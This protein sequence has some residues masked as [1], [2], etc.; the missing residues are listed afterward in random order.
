MRTK[1][2]ELVRKSASSHLELGALLILALLVVRSATA[3]QA[4]LVR[5]F[6]TDASSGEAL[7]GVNVVLRG[8][9][10]LL[11][12]ATD[13]D[14]FYAI[15]RIPPGTYRLEATFV[16]YAPA[17]D[18]LRLEPEAVVVQNLA[19]EPAQ[20]ALDE[21]V[22]EGE[23][24]G[25]AALGDGV[26]TIQ[27]QDIARIPTPGVSG[28]LATYLTS[29]PSVVAPGDQGG[30]L[31]IRGGEPTQNLVLLDG[32][33]VYQP[34]H[35][36]GFYSAFPTDILREVNV[37]P[38]GF[39]PRYG[40][41]LS[42][43]IDVAT[44]NGNN[45]RYGGFASASP[46]VLAAQVEGPLRF[47]RAWLDRRLSFLASARQ[48][49]VEEAAEPLTG[50]TIPYRFGDMFAKLHGVLARNHRLSVSGL[51]TYDR[52]VIGQAE[53]DGGELPPLPRDEVR[54]QNDALGARYLFLPGSLP[55]L[56]DATVSVS[57]LETTFGDPSD[58]DRSATV[59][60]LNSEVH[61]TQF[62]LVEINWGLF[63]RTLAAE[64]DLGGLYQNVDRRREFVT[65]AGL[66]VAPSVRIGSRLRLRPGLRVHAFPSQNDVFL[67]PRVRATWQRGRQQ[68]SAA[69]G[70][71][72]QE[73]V[74]V[75]DRRDAASVFTVWRPVP[76]GQVPR[77]VHLML[78]AERRLGGG[79]TVGAEGYH[80]RLDDLF[81]PEWTAF[82]R[83]TTR[84]QQADGR[85]WGLDARVEA[86]RARVYGYLG[87]GLSSVEYTA[88]QAALPLW[89]GTDAYEYR[90]PHDRRHSLN[91]VL[92]TTLAGIDLSVR[93][94]FG[95]GLPFNQALGFD[96][97]V[98]LDGAVDVFDEVGSRRVVYD[99]PY[100]G[101]LPTYHRLDLGAERTVRLS[102]ATLT[103]Q[104]TLVNAYDR[105]N[106]FYLD[107]FTLRRVDQLPFLPSFGLKVA[108]E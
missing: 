62:G 61:V 64:S 42:S 1:G 27:P 17:V 36:L 86:R 94:Q 54:W 45:R 81:V 13:G 104:A 99:R 58:P 74:G 69:A 44:R 26:Q 47:P 90:P 55:V 34:F 30:Q 4:A 106:L 29:L 35:I 97:F 105:S 46:F 103:V 16:G 48:S 93:W 63:A 53:D 73:I 57:R 92:T 31:F 33:L 23:Q 25:A 71:Y 14:G 38:G 78:G 101:L 76:F 85:V 3:Q 18:T 65:E 96:G 68:V 77:A 40:G 10:V 66:Y 41:R 6:V 11:G 9:E 7:S 75:S 2:H 59:A 50:A 102:A 24:D 22:V 98:L 88:S 49:V 108:F 52:G 56:V 32:M 100:S 95:S 107:V 91:A 15:A 89:F 80:K 39:G 5:G 82:P 60:R 79:V 43:V 12:A 72:H 51:H 67:E 37:Y 83:L 20:A 8:P 28:D 70:V 19:L 87:Y 84:L 21:L